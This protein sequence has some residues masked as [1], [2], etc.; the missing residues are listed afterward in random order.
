MGI[1]RKVLPPQL[2]ECGDALGL[3]VR[4][5]DSQ[6]NIYAGGKYRAYFDATYHFAPRRNQKDLL[7]EYAEHLSDMMYSALRPDFTL[8]K[9]ERFDKNVWEK[10]FAHLV[11]P[12]QEV[13]FYLLGARDQRKANAL[14]PKLEN[15]VKH[16]ISYK[17]DWI[18][19]HEHK[20]I[21]CGRDVSWW[22]YFHS[23]PCP[24]CSGKLRD[25]AHSVKPAG[26]RKL[27]V[28]KA[29]V[30]EE[31]CRSSD[32]VKF[33]LRAKE[34]G[35]SDA[36]ANIMND[37]VMKGFLIGHTV[38]PV[39]EDSNGDEITKWLNHPQI[40]CIFPNE[41]VMASASRTPIPVEMMQQILRKLLKDEFDTYYRLAE[42]QLR[43]K[44]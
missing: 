34:Q 2:Q 25:E 36:E 38:F 44:F 11:Q 37:K 1:W 35:L 29:E 30:L 16:F 21:S 18:G 15:A 33:A 26:G 39:S 19:L 5:S 32:M 10:R 27:S 3:Y 23:E 17:G 8:W 6:D 40:N 22:A 12:S 13:F 24:H 43:S 41:L 4:L 42:G 28:C 9:I 14:L 20:C 31:M 7:Q